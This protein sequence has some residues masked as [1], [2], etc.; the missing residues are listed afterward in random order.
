[1]AFSKPR[2]QTTVEPGALGLG[3]GVGAYPNGP[4]RW[5]RLFAGPELF[6]SSIGLL[7]V[8]Y[9]EGSTIPFLQG[10]SLLA[11]SS[12]EESLRKRKALRITTQIPTDDTR[13]QNHTI[14]LLVEDVERLH[15]SK[16]YDLPQN[17][18]NAKKGMIKRAG[19]QTSF[20][21]FNL[22]W[23]EYG[24]L[25]NELL[26]EIQYHLLCTADLGQT[27]DLWSKDEVLNR[28]NERLRHFMMI[29][30]IVVQ[31]A[32]FLSGTTGSSVLSLTPMLRVL[33]V[34]YDAADPTQLPVYSYINK[35]ILQPTD[36]LQ[37][38]LLFPDWQTS[39][40]TPF[41]YIQDPQRPS[42]ITIVPAMPVNSRVELLFVPFPAEITASSVSLPIPNVFTPFLKW[43]VI[44]D[45]LSKEG[46]A[47]DPERAAYAESLYQLG[48]A[49]A[50][51][52][53]TGELE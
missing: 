35:K 13:E 20:P 41:S 38:D 10:R 47:N 1:M 17:R 33:R 45:L 6:P 39:S 50:K 18:I 14:A 42:E 25:A 29:T 32:F 15:F 19:E 34:S 11:V 52:M 37:A 3:K 36:Q 22:P 49:L 16:L 8:T 28:L 2:M 43:G 40:A 48:L 44:A 46:E 23:T 30:G 27:W 53:Q 51:A 24:V 21:A 31:R 5:D 9:V 4:D 26:N 12:G 7:S